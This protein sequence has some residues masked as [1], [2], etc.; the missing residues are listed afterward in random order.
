MRKINELKEL[1]N[2]VDPVDL[3]EM[4]NLFQED[5]GLPM[6]IW[7]SPKGN[8][9]HGPRIKVSKTY[10]HKDTGRDSFSLTI[11]DDPK[12]IGNLGRIRARDAEKV[13]EWVILNKDLLLAYWNYKI[14]TKSFLNGLTPFEVK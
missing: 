14:S 11:E 4:S 3:W 10:S 2:S 13:M 7:V 6:V 1:I 12:V 9:K 5:T 8:T